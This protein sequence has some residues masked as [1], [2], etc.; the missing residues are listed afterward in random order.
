MKKLFR[1]A[2]SVLGSVAMIGATISGAAATAYPAPFDSGDYAVVYGA[3]SQDSAAANTIAA[4]L[5]E[6]GGT[7]MVGDF[8][9]TDSI[10]DDEVE[11]RTAVTAGAN[12]DIDATLNDGDLG[13]LVDEKFSWDDGGDS[14]A[15]D[16]DIHEEIIVG[17][18]VKPLTTIDDKELTGVALAND[19]GALAYRLV[20]E[21][22]LNITFEDAGTDA[23][24]LYL[25]I[26]GQNYEIEGATNSSITVVTSEEMSLSIGD[27]YTAPNGKVVTLVDVFS[28]SVEISVDGE[29]ET[30]SDGSTERVN[31]VRINVDSVGYHTNTPETSRATLK[32]GEDISKTYTDGEEYIGQ[33]EDDP[34]WVWEIYDLEAAN[35]YIG[36]KYNAK[37]DNEDDEVAGDTIKHVGEGYVFPH[38]FAAITLDGLTDVNYEDL[39]FSFDDSVDLYP[40]SD[41]STPSTENVPVLIVEGADTDT[42]R[43]DGNNETD[44]MYVYYNYAANRTEVYYR[45]HSGDY[46]PT[47]KMRFSTSYAAAVGYTE[48]ATVEVGDTNLDIDL[49]MVSLAGGVVNVTVTND[50]DSDNE[51]MT[52]NITTVTTQGMP[53]VTFEQLGPTAEDADAGDVL[54]DGSD[55]STEDYS[56]MDSYG[57]MIADGTTVENEA[58]DDEATLSI[59]DDQVYATVTVG[60]GAVQ[61]SGSSTTGQKTFM[62]SESSS[63]SNKN[64]VVVGGSCINSV[65]ASLLGGAHCGD[66]FTGA[67][68][69][70]P[71]GFLIETFSYGS[72]KVATVVA[73]Y[74]KDDTTKAA[75][76][77]ANAD[78]SVST[79][80]GDKYKGDTATE[81]AVMVS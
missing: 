17:T 37:L 58:D 72:G 55:R 22:A 5:P 13:G 35:G 12:P 67:T 66:A 19:V 42:I 54:F 74:D 28:G 26:L 11:L 6:M 76:Y 18:A 20:F 45:D 65:A 2:V 41:T 71:G 15:D 62:D 61:S 56:Y 78:N 60:L 1:K 9:F 50:Q 16:Y 57:I 51:V 23:D 38:D 30:I 39:K 59:P 31:G 64:V 21:D 52:L 27:T 4:G 34:L 33:D 79:N 3:N 32:I 75:A 49:G 81:N 24:T 53:A 10:T 80:V 14:G 8:T 36:I 43:V 29:A 47:G 25:E 63:F 48:L 77:L 70:T 68:S 69:I 7:T 44:M 73:G 46:T 40:A